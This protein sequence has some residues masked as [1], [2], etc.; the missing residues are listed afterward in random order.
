MI[1]CYN[2]GLL[3]ITV[4]IVSMPKIYIAYGSRHGL[5]CKMGNLMIMWSTSLCMYL[6]I[7][8]TKCSLSRY[9]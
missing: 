6:D 7:L 2:L 4:N 8:E 5:E 1:T 3:Y 9:G